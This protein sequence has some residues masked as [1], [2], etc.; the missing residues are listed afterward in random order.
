MHEQYIWFVFGFVNKLRVK[1]LKK[2][3]QDS[4]EYGLLKKFANATH[5]SKGL[6]PLELWTEGCPLY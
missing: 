3:K 5:P 6:A 4:L 2:H 1:G